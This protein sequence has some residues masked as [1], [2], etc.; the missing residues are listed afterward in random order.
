MKK[1]IEGI[2][3][4]FCG[5]H[6]AREQSEILNCRINLRKE[7]WHPVVELEDGH[8]KVLWDTEVFENDG[9]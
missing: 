3:R 2:G 5:G 1:E 9:E 8:T 6:L 7:H 4:I